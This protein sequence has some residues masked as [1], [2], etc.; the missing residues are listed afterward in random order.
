MLDQ[1][2]CCIEPDGARDLLKFEL[3]CRSE[4]DNKDSY[5]RHGKLVVPPH[6]D[7]QLLMRIAEELGLTD[8][9]R[10]IMEQEVHSRQS[11]QVPDFVQQYLLFW[12]QLQYSKAQ[13]GVTLEHR[14]DTM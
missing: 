13:R 11:Q 10:V 2:K 6:L 14:A 8:L 7:P 5:P 9:A 3:V 12:K 4:S 1:L